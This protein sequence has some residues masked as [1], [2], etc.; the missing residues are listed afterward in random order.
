MKTSDSAAIIMTLNLILAHMVKEE[1]GVAIFV[2]ISAYW[3]VVAIF[4]KHK[5]Q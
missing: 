2:L 4:R 1:I 5:E 3:A